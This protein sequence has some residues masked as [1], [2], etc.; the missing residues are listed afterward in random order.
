MNVEAESKGHSEDQRESVTF[1]PVSSDQEQVSLII[2]SNEEKETTPTVVAVTHPQP[3]VLDRQ[4]SNNNN[5]GNIGALSDQVLFITKL[6][7]FN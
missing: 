1:V 2:V 6:P 5:N 4:S 3:D 7:S